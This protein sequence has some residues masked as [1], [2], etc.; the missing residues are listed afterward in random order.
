MI[1]NEKK[2]ELSKDNAKWL[3]YAGIFLLIGAPLVLFIQNSLGALAMIFAVA[4]IVLICFG[5]QELRRIDNFYVFKDFIGDRKEVSISDLAKRVQ[6]DSE[7]VIDDL[8]WMAENALFEDVQIDRANDS[9]RSRSYYKRQ[10][11]AV[12]ANTS[13]NI[14]QNKAGMNKQHNPYKPKE[15]DLYYAE[16]CDCCG[17]I[18]KIKVGGGGVCDYC[19]APIGK[20]KK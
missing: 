15:E 4:G 6:C 20:Y 3:V 11:D 9:F 13:G 8:L 14:G 17:G 19:R 12:T 1:T 7:M 16:V 18:T 2:A 10:M 5:K